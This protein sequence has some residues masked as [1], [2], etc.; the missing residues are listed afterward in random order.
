MKYTT[1]I[2]AA[3]K[4]SALGQKEISKKFLT[5]AN[6]IVN[7]RLTEFDFDI[8]VGQVKHFDGA[9]FAETRVL[10]EKEASTIMFIFKSGTN[11][12]RIN[13]TLRHNGEIVW[14]DGNHFCN[15]KSVKS[16]EKLINI[17]V[18][19]NKDIHKLLNEMQLKSDAL[20]LIQ[21]TFYL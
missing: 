9:K 12:H 10:R 16:F 13:T 19:Y 21:R 11:T 7:K 14:H 18:E 2:S 17:I 8:L 4:L 6:E 3:E 20:K 15:R 5:H 1:Y